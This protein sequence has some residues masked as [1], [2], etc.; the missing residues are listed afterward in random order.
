MIANT[1]MIKD[2]VDILLDQYSRMEFAVDFPAC[3]DDI[4]G[5]DANFEIV[6]S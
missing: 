6:C 4:K 2:S 3:Y 1:K 5:E